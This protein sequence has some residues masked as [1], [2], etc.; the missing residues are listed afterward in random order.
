MDMYYFRLLERS[1]SQ[2]VP[3]N[4]APKFLQ[5]P[6]I[7]PYLYLINIINNNISTS[8]AHNAHYLYYI[9]LLLTSSSKNIWLLNNKPF[10]MNND[11]SFLHDSFKIN[12]YHHLHSN[13]FAIVILIIFYFTSIIPRNGNTPLF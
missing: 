3:I 12:K 10:K 4:Y 9:A 8:N 5:H 11:L 13:L 7:T 2:Y 6:P 1:I